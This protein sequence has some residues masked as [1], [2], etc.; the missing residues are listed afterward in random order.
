MEEPGVIFNFLSIRSSI[1][2]PAI[3]LAQVIS[4]DVILKIEFKKKRREKLIKK[5]EKYIWGE[6]VGELFLESL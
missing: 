5:K 1:F 6:I 3:R 2:C 4:Q